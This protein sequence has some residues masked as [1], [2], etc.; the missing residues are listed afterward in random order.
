MTQAPANNPYNIML[1]TVAT[2]TG[3]D[4][5]LMT[6]EEAEWYGERRDRY[7]KDNHFP[8]VSDLQDLDRLLAL[9][10]MLY[11][12][13]LW[14]ARG[15]DYGNVLVDQGALKNSIR[16]YSV[17]TRQLKL[18]LGIDKA[19]RDKDKGESLPDYIANLLNRAKEFGYHRNDQYAMVV[20]K[21][22][23]LHTMVMTY[24][25]CDQEEREILD[26]SL[27]TIFQWIRDNVLADFDALSAGF[28]KQQAIWI[29]EM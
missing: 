7:L 9:E 21:F 10:V 1:Y 19:T 5:H 6:L 29:R 18:A 23:E 26:L 22:Y 28:R 3:S 11:R 27:E 17:E 13:I 25:R 8:N 24:D 2:P 14:M 12:W 15:F 16:E 4:L 20:T